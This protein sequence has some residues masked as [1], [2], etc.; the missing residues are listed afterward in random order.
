MPRSKFTP[1]ARYRHLC[2]NDLELIIDKVQYVGPDYTKLKVK[3][4][5]RDFGAGGYLLDWASHAVTIKKD[6]YDM[7]RRVG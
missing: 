5:R 6:Q 4:W 1:G 7:W 3:Y 2:G